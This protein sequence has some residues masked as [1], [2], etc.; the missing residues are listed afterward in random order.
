MTESRRAPHEFK[1]RNGHQVVLNQSDDIWQAANDRLHLVHD[2]RLGELLVANGVITPEQ[3]QEVLALQ[4]RGV[5]RP[6][7]RLLRERRWVTDDELNVA[8]AASVNM[9]VVDCASVQP[10]KSALTAVPGELAV[11]AQV[12]PLMLRQSTLVVAM[13]D[14]WQRPILDELSFLTN[15]RILPVM[16]EPGTLVDA[17]Q[18]AYEGFRPGKADGAALVPPLINW[19]SSSPTRCPK[20]ATK[21]VTSSPSPAV[22][23]SGWSTP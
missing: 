4:Q 12:L 13:D 20:P 10:D 6:V 14:P 22:P 16:A 5:H 11:R 17:V 18:R 23:W 3:L 15:L 8:L 2:C 1:S 21:P 7:G 19:P 9:P